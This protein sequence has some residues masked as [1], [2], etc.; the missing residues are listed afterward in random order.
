[1]KLSPLPCWKTLGSERRIQ[2]IRDLLSEIE[3]EGRADRETGGVPV[4]D[5]RKAVAQHPHHRPDRHKS[6]PAPMVHAA[7]R[8]ARRELIKAY[9]M[10]VGSYREAVEAMRE[11]LLVK[12]PPE[13]FPPPQYCPIARAGP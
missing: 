6:G 2:A 13:C 11:G 8:E 7:N 10:F 5:A 1:M 9:R 4:L 12:F 3:A